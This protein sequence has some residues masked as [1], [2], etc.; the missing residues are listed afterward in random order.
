M[1][2]SHAEDA[3]SL[4][5]AHH[6]PPVVAYARLDTF[7]TASGSPTVVVSDSVVVPDSG[8]IFVSF[9]AT[10]K[11]DL[12]LTVSPPYF[13]TKPYIADYG[14]SIDLPAAIQYKV[15]SSMTETEFWLAGNFVPTKPVAGSAVFKVTTPGKHM[16]YFLTEVAL[17][18]EDD[19]ARSVLENISLSAI[20]IQHNS[21]SMQGAM[22]LGSG[23]KGPSS[24]GP[25]GR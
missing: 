17:D 10:Q 14:V 23:G 24:Q 12:T 21:A 6:I 8:F 4:P 20:F 11:M 22:L 3:R 5:L 13:V 1:E 25:V 19:G 2:I 15:R 16:V 18:I 9:S 7:S